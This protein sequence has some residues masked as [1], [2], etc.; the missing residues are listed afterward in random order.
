MGPQSVRKGTNVSTRI[1]SSKASR[2]G[3]FLVGMVGGVVAAGYVALVMSNAGWNPTSLLAQG[4]D[5]KAQLEYAEREL[6]GVV[7]TRPDLGHDGRFFFVLANDPFLLHPS[8]HATFLDQPAYR[9]Q[10]ILYPMLA[11]GFGSLPPGGVVWGLVSVN[12]LMVAVGSYAT[13][14]VATAL[15]ASRW[16]GLAFAVSPGTIAEIDI[17]GGGVVALAL[18]MLGLLAIIRGAAGLGTLALTSA[19]LARETMILF[20]V[21][22]FVWWWR[23]QGSVRLSLLIAPVLAAIAWRTYAG[24]RLSG[25]ETNGMALEGVIRNFE[26]VPLLGAIEASTRW[27]DDPAKLIWTLCLVAIILLFARRAW[28]SRSAI[29]WSSWPFA[30]LCLFLSAF[31]WTEPYDIARAV[32]PV[33]VAYPLLL[34]AKRKSELRWQPDA[35]G[36][37]HTGGTEKA[38]TTK[39]WTKSSSSI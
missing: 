24:L 26:A 32:A 27:L 4:I 16:V 10:R 22:L 35:S 23:E 20:A 6:G 31:V 33:F 1:G 29:A 9:A 12:L 11:G 25:I 17:N 5:S 21:G 2:K 28:S 37:R 15:G 30:G 19:V 14:G 7:V 36:D 8:I 39:A 34:F 38:A 13:A 18:G 3:G